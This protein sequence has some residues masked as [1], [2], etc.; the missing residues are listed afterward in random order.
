M[1]QALNSGYAGSSA[2]FVDANSVIAERGFMIPSGIILD[3]RVTAQSAINTVSNIKT[4]ST[5]S[6]PRTASAAKNLCFGTAFDSCGFNATDPRPFSASC[7]TKVALAAG[8][9]S[10]GTAMPSA[11]IGVWN[12]LAT[13][14]D[15]IA[16]VNSWKQIADTPGPN[17]LNYIHRVYGVNARYPEQCPAGITGCEN[18]S[19]RLNCKSGVI[20]GVNIKYG[21]WNPGTCPG[22]NS[23]TKQQMFYEKTVMPPECIAKKSCNLT[24]DNRYGDSFPGTKKEWIASAICGST[25]PVT[26]CENDTATLGCST[27]TIQGINLKY[28]KWNKDSCPGSN[29]HTSQ[30]QFAEGVVTA[31]ECVGQQSC[32]VRINNRWGD[33]FG[34]TMKEWV[35]SPVCG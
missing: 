33:P 14:G 19:G 24:V 18:E 34:G 15:V 26:G 17:Q 28:G 30:K 8:W 2:A 7:I 6:N 4:W 23:D 32:T 5:D 11:N 22:P 20:T 29:S 31:Q 27:G 25:V 9:L 21:K 10:Q 16:Q 13:W 35:A 3:G 1:S 12:N